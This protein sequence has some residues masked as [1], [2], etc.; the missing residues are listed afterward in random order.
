MVKS[1]FFFRDRS[2]SS[3]KSTVITPY[4]T[5]HNNYIGVYIFQL[6]RVHISL[7]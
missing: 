5:G 3:V 6:Y 7:S 1:Q 2:E 4:F